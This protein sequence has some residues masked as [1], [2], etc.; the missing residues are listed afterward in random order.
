MTAKIA[1]AFYD[2]PHKDGSLEFAVTIFLK[3][4]YA[5]FWG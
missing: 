5:I 1:I 4:G 3:C 2:T